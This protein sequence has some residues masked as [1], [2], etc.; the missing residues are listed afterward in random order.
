MI[1]IFLTFSTTGF[2]LAIILLLASLFVG[3]ERKLK[4]TV[5]RT[6]L[7]L[8]VAVIAVSI[9]AN[10]KFDIDIG[11]QLYN[12]V[13]GKLTGDSE[14]SKNE[15]L[16]YED[17]AQSTHN[18][19]ELAKDNPILGIGKAKDENKIFV[20]S[21]L[22]EIGYQFGFIYLI[23][24][25]LLFRIIFKPLGFVISVTFCLI[26][27]NGEAYAFLIL[28][29]I[30]IV[31]GAKEAVMISPMIEKLFLKSLTASTNET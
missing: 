17:R 16:S 9:Y 26:M 7:V 13:I 21:S 18:A 29:S 14:S 20:T 10:A 27:M 19:F 24:Y 23:V 4:I 2:F 11:Q 31:Y 8:V 30:I 3:K 6:L 28:S 12:Q 25:I 15:V 1:S 22:A 5:F